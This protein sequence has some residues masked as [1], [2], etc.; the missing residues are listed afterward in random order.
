M[1]WDQLI[2]SAH[3]ARDRR[4]RCTRINEVLRGE[5]GKV[6]YRTN[7]ERGSI[8]I[9]NTGLCG[10][11]DERQEKL[12]TCYLLSIKRAKQI[13]SQNQQHLPAQLIKR[14]Q[15]NEQKY[16]KLYHEML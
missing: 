12:I 1:E 3:I 15:K 8:Y 9:S 11:V 5:W 2:I 13:Y 10:I 7:T 14:I 4:D 16:F 6:I